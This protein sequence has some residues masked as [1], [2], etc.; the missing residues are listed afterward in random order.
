MLRKTSVAPPEWTPPA[1]NK[2]RQCL[3]ISVI[4]PLFGGGPEPRTVVA[5]EPVRPASV[6]GHLRYW[7]RVLYGVSFQSPDKLFEQERE[8]WGSAETFG[9]VELSVRVTDRGTD[10]TCSQLAGTPHPRTGPGLGYFLFPFAAEKATNTPEAV[11]KMGIKFS[12]TLEFPTA[13]TSALENTLKAWLTF[14]G[15]GARTR[16]GCGALS[17]PQQYLPPHAP[18]DLEK[19]LSSLCAHDPVQSPATTLLHGSS[20][21]LGPKCSNAMEAW[22][23]L[24]RFWAAFRKGHVAGVPYQPMSGGHW[25]D[26]GTL[27]TLSSA[28][29]KRV[30]LNKPYLGLPIIYQEVRGARFK[31]S[32]EPT[33]SGRMASPVILKPIVLQDKSVRPALLVLRAPEPEGVRLRETGAYYDLV[34]N[35]GDEVLKRLGGVG[36]LGAVIEAAKR[37]FGKDCLVFTIG[38][39]K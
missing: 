37:H 5:V 30:R 32:L 35:L 25:S 3:D 17:G 33:C 36:P 13:Y 15:I 19:W 22:E 8:L 20:L 24:A 21:L 29:T 1:K 28:K 12:L 34:A 39:T 11:G 16:R 14:G 2:V 27:A 38:G 6:R 10:T 26:Y 7:W 9:Q 4:L 23:Q 31:G 18:P